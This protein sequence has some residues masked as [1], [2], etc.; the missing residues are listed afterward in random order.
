MV[1]CGVFLDALA[2]AIELGGLPDFHTLRATGAQN[3]RISVQPRDLPSWAGYFDRRPGYVE[4][5]L[6]EASRGRTVK[7]GR[8]HFVI[9]HLA[10]CLLE[11]D[12]SPYRPTAPPT[13]RAGGGDEG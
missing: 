9:T 2:R 3:W 6:A 12:D 4:G 7:L 5:V 10:G 11:I 1:P 13:P 8:E